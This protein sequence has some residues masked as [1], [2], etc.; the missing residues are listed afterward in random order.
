MTKV[1]GISKAFG[2]LVV[3][4]VLIGPATAGADWTGYPMLALIHYN[5]TSAIL[6]ANFDEADFTAEEA[7]SISTEVADLTGML[8]GT[9]AEVYVLTP[10]QLSSY[11][12]TSFPAL[13]EFIDPR[14]HDYGFQFYIVL[15]IYKAEGMP[16]YGDGKNIVMDVWVDNLG[17]GMGLPTNDLYLGSI[18][19]PSFY[20]SLSPGLM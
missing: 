15:N 5:D 19:I 8:I 1:K 9:G 10:E 13:D 17:T 12:Y 18:S 16:G 3:L 14:Y 2:F 4:V 20:L 7:Q 6:S 11:G